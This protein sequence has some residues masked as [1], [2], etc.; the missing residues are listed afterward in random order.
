MSSPAANFRRLVRR[1]KKD[2]D[3]RIFAGVDRKKIISDEEGRLAVVVTVERSIL[4]TC[5]R[6]RIDPSFLGFRP[7]IDVKAEETE[8][9][10]APIVKVEIGKGSE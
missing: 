4:E 5:E 9:R 2:L 6:F 1:M 8:G 10:L 3:R 7:S